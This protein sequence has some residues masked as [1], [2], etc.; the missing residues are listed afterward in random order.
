MQ[1]EKVKNYRLPVGTKVVIS[2]DLVDRKFHGHGG[3]IVVP[4]RKYAGMETTIK[5]VQNNRYYRLEVD[6]GVWRWP[7]DALILI[8]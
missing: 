2:H 5:C 3:I 1:Q 7:C 6:G 8:E 4:M